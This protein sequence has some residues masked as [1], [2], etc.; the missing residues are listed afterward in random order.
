MSEKNIVND[1]IDLTQL[2]LTIWDNKFKVIMIMGIVMVGFFSYHYKQKSYFIATTEIKNISSF[3][4]FNYQSLNSYLDSM[5][6]KRKKNSNA[7]DVDGQLEEIQNT[8]NI[9]QKIDKSYLLHLF[10]NEIKEGEII[11]SAI[12]EY[13]LIDKNNYQNDR[14]YE[15][16]IIRMASSIKILPPDQNNRQEI[17]NNWKLQFTTYDKKKWEN[18]LKNIEKPINENVKLYLSEVFKNLISN[19]KKI[20]S[21]QIEDINQDIEIYL[22]NYEKKMEQRLAFLD[23]QY[24]IAKKLDIPTINYSL[25]QTFTFNNNS[26]EETD[27][28]LIA[29]IPYYMRG[30]EMIEEEIRLIK[31]RTNKEPFIEE[32]N[33][34][35]KQK[36][37][38]LLNKDIE[39]L[40][41]LILSTP[42]FNDQE[43]VA[44]NLSY[45]TTNFK[46]SKRPIRRVMIL[47]ILLGLISGIVYVLM[48]KVIKSRK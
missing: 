36:S 37:N 38:L 27:L 12:K 16:A 30:Y 32:L 2:I 43:F 26:L 33:E 20:Y 35:E 40:E 46:S 39:R 23:E 19:Q 48:A 13:N 31:N 45:L 10:I 6:E 42:I 17:N 47:S 4:E 21:F 15:N 44:A 1:E 7:E 3:D 25:P 28:N 18:F 11:K 29:E 41:K 34:L 8:F 22:I 5:N 24:Q 14:D 9:F